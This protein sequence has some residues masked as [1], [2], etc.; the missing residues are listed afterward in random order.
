MRASQATFRRCTATEVVVDLP[1]AE[2]VRC[3]RERGHQPPHHCPHGFHWTRGATLSSTSSAVTC[4]SADSRWKHGRRGTV[5]SRE[6]TPRRRGTV[7]SGPRRAPSARP[8]RRSTRPTFASTRPRTS[9][10]HARHPKTGLRHATLL[11]RGRGCR[12]DAALTALG[13]PDEASRR[14]GLRKIREADQVKRYG[15]VVV[16]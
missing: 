6:S 7:S 13:Y 4:S 5:R 8:S 3:V 2:D 12:V 16:T 11:N 9:C 1:G 14:E 10:S 15:R